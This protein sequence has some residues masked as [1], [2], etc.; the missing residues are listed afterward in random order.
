MEFHMR[1]RPEVNHRMP[2]LLIVFFGA[3]V[4]AVH[5][6]N[7]RATPGHDPGNQ[8]YSPLAQINTKNVSKL[9]PAWTYQLRK[10]GALFRPSES[11]PL[12][13]NGVLYISWPRFHLAALEPETGNF[14]REYPH[15]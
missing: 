7:D 11:I 1:N 6:Q 2:L 14:L 10:E 13:V 8:R 5:A 3:C 12:F 15:P 9:V 4:S